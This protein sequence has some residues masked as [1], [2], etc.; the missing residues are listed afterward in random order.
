MGLGVW[1]CRGGAAAGWSGQVISLLH[2]G[3]WR[4]L[5]VA[6]G[7]LHL[8]GG[9]VAILQ[10]LAWAGMLVCYSAEDGLVRG[11]VDTFSGERPCALCLK[12]REMDRKTPE[13]VLP[14]GDDQR[15][16]A[17][18]LAQSLRATD[19]TELPPPPAR[20]P[21]LWDV[22]L[23]DEKRPEDPGSGP[24]PPPPRRCA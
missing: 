2:S 12:V 19:L 10:S 4:H 8:L 15:R 16:L 24:E 9:P 6:L 14:T 21:G 5:L 20:T 3:W 18:A 23:I 11:V 22:G 13:P 7:C 1:A 17:E